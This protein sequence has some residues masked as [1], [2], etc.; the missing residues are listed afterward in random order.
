M[1]YRLPA[2]ILVFAAPLVL[3]II[4]ARVVWEVTVDAAR[5]IWEAAWKP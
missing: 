2:Y 5:V 4:L 1:K 3:A